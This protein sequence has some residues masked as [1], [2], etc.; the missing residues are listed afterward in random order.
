MKCMDAIKTESRK[1]AFFVCSVMR[2]LHHKLVSAIRPLGSGVSAMAHTNRP[3][4]DSRTLRV[5]D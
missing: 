4:L 1:K 3:T 5:R 2:K